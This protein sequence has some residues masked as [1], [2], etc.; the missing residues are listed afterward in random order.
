[1]KTKHIISSITPLACAIGLNC[2][3][4]NS[5][6]SA[7]LSFTYTFDSSETISGSFEGDIIPGTTE[8]ENLSNLNAIYSGA[9]DVIFD[10][11]DTGSSFNTDSSQ[12]FSFIGE[13]TPNTGNFFSIIGGANSDV[14]V[15]IPSADI[16]EFDSTP[17]ASRFEVNVDDA[18]ATT[19][20]S[21]ITLALVS[22]GGLG[23]FQKMRKKQV[24]IQ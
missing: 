21:G 1:M 12:F 7:N 4:I 3:G 15:T 17:V 22:L 11:I 20:E 2:L 13:Q 5:A 8:Y 16:F 23:F 18:V 10:T 14:S 24:T 6:S 9:P 19:P